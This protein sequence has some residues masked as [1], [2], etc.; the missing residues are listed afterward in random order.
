MWE[1][2]LRFI[3]SRYPDL[4]GKISTITLKRLDYV[5][6]VRPLWEVPLGQRVRDLLNF[7]VPRS[8]EGL[9]EEWLGELNLP[10]RIRAI[11]T[12]PTIVAHA[13]VHRLSTV[14]QVQEPV[15]VP[16]GLV[17]PG[18]DQQGDVVAGLALRPLP[19]WFMVVATLG[20]GFGVGGIGRA[21][22]LCAGVG[23]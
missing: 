6:D 17:V 19:G 21:A 13:P 2:A 9:P 15:S 3:T 11:Q 18:R 4:A 22:A 8:G 16:A 1:A 12:T 10:V 20:S 23:R 5:Q 14:D 7:D